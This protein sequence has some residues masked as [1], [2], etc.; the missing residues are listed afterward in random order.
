MTSRILICNNSSIPDSDISAQLSADPD[1]YLTFDNKYFSV[2]VQI[3]F[4]T[5]VPVEEISDTVEAFVYVVDEPTSDAQS[6]LRGVEVFSEFLSDVEPTVK[7]LLINCEESRYESEFLEWCVE[8]EFEFIKYIVSDSGSEDTL[9]GQS[10]GMGRV[11]AALECHMWPYRTM[12]HSAASNDNHTENGGTDEFGEYASGAGPLVDFQS[13]MEGEE[14]EA[15]FETMFSN[16]MKMKEVAG[17]LPDPERKR[18]AEQV[19]MSFWR[20]LGGSDD[21]L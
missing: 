15:D 21:E 13:L 6:A 17:Q 12:K 18:F 11:R 9:M 2:S 10:E 3:C 19:A 16:M 8:H 20:A 5:R 4:D 1:N 7:L 14:L